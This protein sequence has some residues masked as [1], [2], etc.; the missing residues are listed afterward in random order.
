MKP[1][2]SQL[3]TSGPF[4]TLNGT[5]RLKDIAPLVRRT[6]YESWPVLAKNGVVGLLRR[7]D[8]D[9]ALEHDLG[10]LTVHDIMHA[11]FPRL[12]EEEELSAVE[13]ALAQHGWDCLPVLDGSGRLRGMISR[14]DLLRYHTEIPASGRLAALPQTPHGELIQR[15]ADV[16]RAAGTGLWLVGGSV[17]DL[18]L[19]RPCDDLDF[20][21]DSEPQRLARLIQTRLGGTTGPITPFG[22][23]RWYPDDKTADRLSLTASLLPE[24]VDFAGARAETYATQAALPHVFGS[25]LQQD[26]LRR[27]FTINALAIPVAPVA[28]PVVDPT[29]GLDDL[30]AGLIR[31]LHPLSF[32]D[33]PLRILRAWRFRSRFGFKIE[34]RTVELMQIARPALGEI[35]GSRLRNEIDLLL[36]EEC[37]GAILS[38]MQQFDLLTAIHPAFRV[39]DDIEARLQRSREAQGLPSCSDAP[40]RLWHALV[41]DME[42]DSLPSFCERLLMAPKLARSMEAT[43]RLLRQPGILAEKG[44]GTFQVVGRL[45]PLPNS[46]V[47]CLALL[48]DNPLVRNRLGDWLRRW[49]NIKVFST[50]RDV[51]AAGLSPGPAF[52]RIL[53]KLRVAWYEGRITSEAEERS[54]LG[55]LAAA[56]RR[57]ARNGDVDWSD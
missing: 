44:A 28:G 47:C 9:R 15:V 18:L 4:Q 51:H 1:R 11:D 24:H 43:A 52:A 14:G 12:R 13:A 8:L 3:M 7:Q 6:G 54:L 57:T 20:V 36:Q 32:H 2:A 5:A 48:T 50:G 25:N 26:L 35:T 56:E 22:T 38:N 39:P 55:Q 45:L 34:P 40:S 30:D 10:S 19:G 29:G 21:V 42:P 37:P 27:D 41:S 33:D 31:V 46:A 53:L 17:R 23:F 49:P 16:A